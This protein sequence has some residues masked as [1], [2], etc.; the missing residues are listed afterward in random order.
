MLIR[1][2]TL[3]SRL[4]FRTLYMIS[5]VVYVVLYHLV[6]YRKDIVR[7]NL[8]S[9]FPDKSKTELREIER[10]FYHWL[11]DYFVETLKLLTITPEEMRKHMEWDGLEQIYASFDRGQNISVF[12]GHHCNWEWLSSI[13]V[14]YDGKYSNAANGL[15]Y[16][17]L[18]ND[19]MDELMIRLRSHLGGVCINKNQILRQLVTFRKENR[20]YILGFIMD[21]GPKYQ[22]IHL[23]L[24]F[25]NH[26]ETPVFTGGERITRKMNNTVLFLRMERPERG[27]Y[28]AHFTTVS[29]SPAEEP[30]NAITRKCFAMLEESVRKNPE[31]YLWSHNRWKRTY[32]EFVRREKANDNV[33]KN[34]KG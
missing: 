23:W 3:I 2:I 9:A 27:K 11:C 12:L 4:S 5:D 25:L 18:R 22:N 32:E 6:G 1:F 16:H 26:P 24:D 31:Y 17:A 13:G 28:V 19:T 7:S 33:K 34:Y 10:K 15:I 21:Q 29:T 30:E 20:P 14:F 8:S